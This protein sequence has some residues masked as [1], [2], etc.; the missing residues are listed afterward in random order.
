MCF[1]VCLR[2]QLMLKHKPRKAFCRLWLLRPEESVPLRVPSPGT[3]FSCLVVGVMTLISFLPC[4][5]DFLVGW[6]T[7]G[8]AW[9]F[10]LL[11]REG[12]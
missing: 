9:L 10:L 3:S 6:L 1:M 8:P 7:R 5:G 4:L 2:R 12:Q 11:F